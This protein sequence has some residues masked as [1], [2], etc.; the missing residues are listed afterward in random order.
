MIGHPKTQKQVQNDVEWAIFG[1]LSYRNRNGDKPIF[2]SGKPRNPDYQDPDYR[3]WSIVEDALASLGGAWQDGDRALLAHVFE[4]VEPVDRFDFRRVLGDRFGFGALRWL[5]GCDPVVWARR[6]L[7]LI[8]TRI[9]GHIESQP[10][11]LK[12]RLIDPH[13][14]ITG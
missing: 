4:L 7:E 5:M 13:A 10:T 12:T 6:R 9:A 2:A 14:P 1:W 8:R 3:A 11:V